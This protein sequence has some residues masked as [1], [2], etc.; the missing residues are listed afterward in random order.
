MFELPSNGVKADWAV[1]AIMAGTIGVA[2][3]AATLWFIFYRPKSK[4]HRRKK[5]RRKRHSR[6]H[7]PTLAQTGGL[8]PPRDPNKPPPGL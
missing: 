8:P 3:C 2:V 6:Q 7:N 5:H 4:K 1:F